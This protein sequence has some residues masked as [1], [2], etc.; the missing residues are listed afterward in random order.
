MR[1]N[2]HG[3]ITSV[4]DRRSIPASAGEP[5][6]RSPRAGNSRVYPR[7]C[8]GT[9]AAVGVVTSA[10]GLSPRVRGNLQLPPDPKA[11]AGSIPAS[12][13]EPRSPAGPAS[14]PWVYPREC[15]GTTPYCA[16]R[17][18]TPGLSPRVRGNLA[19]DHA[20]KRADRSIPAS[21]GEPPR[22]IAFAHATWVYPRE[23]GGTRRPAL[24][25]RGRRGLSPRV[26]GNLLDRVDADNLRR[27]IPASA[28]EPGHPPCGQS[29]Q[30]V[31]PRECG[32]T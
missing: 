2:R 23:C 6:S 32:G 8:G 20:E 11:G 30:P 14:G 26:R 28:G 15:G 13:G 29:G 3:Q 25:C 17:S 27:S 16:R 1:G 4:A 12:A 22:S 9:R 7:E 31:Y 10:P 5:S 19:Q 24:R 18:S 21:A